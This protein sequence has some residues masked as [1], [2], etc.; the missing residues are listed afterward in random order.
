MPGQMRISMDPVQAAGVAFQGSVW[1]SGAQVND[2]V[3]I[4]L[5][6]TAGVAPFYVDTRS[7]V[8]DGDC[9]GIVVFDNV[10]LH[11]VNSRARL[12]AD[13]DQSAVPLMS[14]DIHVDVVAP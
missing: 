4:R 13:D 1:I 5:W 9:K 7:T 14:D 11:G 3:T 6:Q 10:V 2:T 8:I 12:M